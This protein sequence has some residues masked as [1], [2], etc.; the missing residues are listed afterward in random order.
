MYS[1]LYR[2]QSAFVCV[3]LLELHLS[4]VKEAKQVVPQAEQLDGKEVGF[5]VQ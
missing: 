2:L 4:T 3:I 1:A 5:A